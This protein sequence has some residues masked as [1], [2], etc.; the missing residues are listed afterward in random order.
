VPLESNPARGRI[1]SDKPFARE[2][3]REA[4]ATDGGANR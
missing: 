1:E 4:L 2:E 3:H